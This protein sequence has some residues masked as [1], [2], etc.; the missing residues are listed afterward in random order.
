MRRQNNDPEGTRLPIKIDSTSNGEFEP[1]PL[2]QRNIAGNIEA[3]RLASDNARRL[4]MGRRAFLVSA[5]GAATTLL[6]FNQ[7]NKAYAKT[8]GYFD[9]DAEAGLDQHA[10]AA[11]LEGR[12]FIFDVQGHYVNPQGQWLKD[13]LER[14]PSARPFANF[15]RSRIP[16]EAFDEPD[17]G[18][19][20][21]L[22][23]EAFIKDIFMD[24]DTDMMVLS[25]V[26]SQMESEP[27]TIESAD[28]TR[29][30][31][32]DLEGT[33]R[34]LL[35]GRVNPNQLGDMDR[36]PELA[37]QWGISAWKCYTQY[38]PDRVGF[39]LD[40][41]VGI[42][43]IE[44][45][46]E[47]GVKVICIH[48]GLPFGQQSYEHSLSR[49][50]GIVA[51]RYPEVSFIAYHAG[52]ESQ[53]EETQ[54]E[55]GSGKSGI[56]SLVQ[57]VIDNDIPS[58]ANVYAELGSTWRA[59]MR[60]PDQAAHGMGKLLTHLGEDN[61]LW[62]T[63]S[64]WYGSPQDQIQA[65]RTFQ[66]SDEFQERY[67]YPEITAEIRAKIF[68]LNATKPY[69]ISAE[70]VQQR[71]SLDKIQRRKQAYMEAPDPHFQTFGPK[72][73]REFLALQ[74]NEGTPIMGEH[75]G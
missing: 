67:G 75:D 8:G 11:A 3:I 68:G 19:L 34:L 32:E 49:D 1:V 10:A 29:R 27:V 60:D 55:V 64:I 7:V 40:D 69:K 70:E 6:A 41:E 47:S 14:T 51:K 71:A 23:H 46:I 5:S 50:I 18:Y 35:H 39:F 65:F 25:F 73:R 24:S 43:F 37:D 52:Y 9:L 16:P 13:M 21:Y 17:H 22:N 74:R 38:G 33:Q 59:L 31:V 26:P 66:I 44:R 57:S 48:K 30:I 63:D 20:R 2:S 28:A 56:D 12:E 72:N 58:G 45:A 62:G 36:M 54:F 53:T 61:I 42:E 4:G 15:I